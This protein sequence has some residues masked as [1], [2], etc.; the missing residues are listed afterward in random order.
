MKWRKGV[1]AAKKN[2][3]WYLEDQSILKHIE[4]KDAAIVELMEQGIYENKE[5]IRYLVEKNGTDEVAAAFLLAQFM[6]DY[7]DYI[8]VS[9]EIT[10]IEP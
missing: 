5:I 9:Q 7:M 10:V 2:G 6:V 1:I 4:K 8:G 3:E